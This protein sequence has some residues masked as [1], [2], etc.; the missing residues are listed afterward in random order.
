MYQ[1]GKL[2]FDPLAVFTGAEL[3]RFFLHSEVVAPPNWP[4]SPM[5][6]VTVSCTYLSLEKEGDSEGPATPQAS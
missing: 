6:G 2:S 4:S 5:V 3:T 1:R